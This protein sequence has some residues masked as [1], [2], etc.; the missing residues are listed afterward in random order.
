V[1]TV[2]LAAGGLGVMASAFIVVVAACI[3]TYWFRYTCVLILNTKKSKNYARN[4]ADANGLHFLAI[5]DEL[6][7]SGSRRLHEIHSLLESDYR[8]VMY[9][10]QHASGY[11]SGAQMFER[12]ILQMDYRLLR[13]WYQLARGVSQSLTR[14]SLIERTAVVHHLANAVGE[15]TDLSRA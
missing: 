13:L 1:K 15:R 6:S 8:V 9:L 2:P 7:A 10:L 3:L 14:R 4:V 5:G 11:T 12:F